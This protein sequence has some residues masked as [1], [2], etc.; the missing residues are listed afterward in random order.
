MQILPNSSHFDSVLELRNAILKYYDY[1]KLP[2]ERSDV[3]TIF[4]HPEEN[5]FEVLLRKNSEKILIPDSNQ[6]PFLYRGQ[7]IDY[8]PCLPTLYRNNPT[9]IQIF[10]ERLRQ[11]EFSF[12]LEQHPVVKS[13]FKR[14]NFRI[15]NIGLAQHYG[16]KTLII[17][18]TNNIDIA[19][20]FAM[21]QYKKDTDCYEPI[22]FEGIHKAVLHIIVP[23]LLISSNSGIFLEDKISVI[24]LQPFLRPGIQK[25]FSFSLNR[26]ESLHSFKYS[27]NYTKGDSEYY[28]EKF[29]KG[30]KL[31]IKDILA[32][33]AKIISSKTNFSLTTFNKTWDY[34]PIRSVSKN[35]LR[36]SL[37]ASNILISTHNKITSFSENEIED[38]IQKWNN[39]Q[40]DLFIRQVR[41][42]F[43]NEIAEDKKAGKRHEFRTLEMLKEIELLRLLGNRSGIDEY[44]KNSNNNINSNKYLNE[45]VDS[46]RKKI[47]GHF[48][49]AKSEIFLKRNECIIDSFTNQ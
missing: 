13:V 23:T 16:L 8:V 44:I 46:V 39:E 2:Y 41:R 36:K 29:E 5:T 1:F 31:W 37:L 3:N 42:K 30:E 19:L 6:Y 43:W 15:D 12:L 9:D 38:I 47:P 22:Q 14:N 11:I 25:G 7:Q 48:E 18:L 26:N 32:D 4:F 10:I 27:F 33:K 17:D 24:G 20:F 49:L 28:Y 34:Y 21:C 45:K 35:K 40:V